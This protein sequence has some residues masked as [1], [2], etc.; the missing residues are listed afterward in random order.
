MA[1]AIFLIIATTNG[2]GASGGNNPGVVTGLETQTIGPS[3][4]N[5]KWTYPTNIT[6][7]SD[8]RQGGLEM[9][10]SAKKSLS[11]A[12]RYLN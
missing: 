7:D 5:V 10:C 9:R 1:V 8:M 4:M 2:N 11:R 6:I 3:S 12:S